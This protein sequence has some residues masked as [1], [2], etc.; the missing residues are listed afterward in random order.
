MFEREWCIHVSGIWSASAFPASLF[1]V[2]CSARVAVMKCIV[3][4]MFRCG[5]GFGERSAERRADELHA[6]SAAQL[7]RF[8]ALIPAVR[9]G[10]SGRGHAGGALHGV[11]SARQLGRVRVQLANA[12]DRRVAV[13]SG[14]ERRL[15]DADAAVGEAGAHQT[16]AP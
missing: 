7:R 14:C 8:F 15:T 12:A 1:I 16:E 5:S 4:V 11:P 9:A 3:Y 6:L 13:C 10:R 2:R